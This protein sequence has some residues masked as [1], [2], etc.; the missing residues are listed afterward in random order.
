MGKGQSIKGLES[1]SK[2]FGLDLEREAHRRA[3]KKIVT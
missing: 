1:H 3:T 2:M